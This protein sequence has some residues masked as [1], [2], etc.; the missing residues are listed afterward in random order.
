MYFDNDQQYGFLPTTIDQNVF[1]INDIKIFNETFTI[2]ENGIIFFVVNNLDGKSDFIWSLTNIVTGEEIIRV[3]S[4]PFFI[5]K[6]KDIGNFSLKVEVID[7]RETNYQTIV[8]NF[9]RVL[10]KNEYLLD[11]EDRLNTR[12]NKLIKNHTH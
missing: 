8:Q 10:G 12:K 4:V 5:W 1:N 3:K 6:F 9:I 7:N 2:P 11:V